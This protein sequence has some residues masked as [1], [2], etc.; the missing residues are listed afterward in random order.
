MKKADRKLLRQSNQKSELQKILQLTA[1]IVAHGVAAS[2]N[3]EVT[4]APAGPAEGAVGGTAASVGQTNTPAQLPEVV[5]TGQHH[6]SYKPVTPQL[7]KLTEPLRDTP[8]SITV[9]PRQVLDDQNATTLRDALRNVAGISIAA[10]EGGSQGDNLTLRG[11]TARG[12]IF[13]D[14]MRDFGSYYRDPFNMGEV[15]VL[16]GPESVM[17]GRGS[18]GGVINQQ[19]KTPELHPFT[20]ATLSLGS[21]LTRRATADFN[22]PI[23]ALGTGTAFRLNMMGH[24]SEVAERDVAQNRRFG[25]A[26]TLEFGI[27]TPTRLT[28]SYFH[29]SEDNIPD[30]GI[31]WLFDHPAPVSRDNFYGFETDYLKTD[32]DIVTARLESEVNQNITLRD[33]ARFGYYQRDFRITEPRIATGVTPTTPHSAIGITRNELAGKSVES[34]LDNQLDLTARF[35][36][37][38]IEHTVVTGVEISR[39]TSDPTRYA[40]TGVP[41]TSLVNPN[42]N[43]RFAGTSTV[44]SDVRTTALGAGLYALESMKLNEHLELSGGI[45][46]DYFDADYSNLNTQKFS[47]I[48]RMPSWRAAAVYKPVQKGSIYFDYGTSFNPSAESLSLSAANVD[49]APEKNQTFELGT[50]W[51][52]LDERLSLRAAIFRTD[53]TNVREP[54]PNDPTQ[55]VL[56]GVQRVDG[57]EVEAAGRLTKNWQV[58]SGYSYM[59]GEVMES[60]FYPGSVGKPLAN[61]PKNTFSLWTTYELPWK[62]ELGS[63]FH[64]V[65]ARTASSTVPI[66]PT[67]LKRKEAPGYW[68]LDALV[69]YHF[70]T[71]LEFQLNVYNI[72][73]NK[74][75][76]QLHPGHIVP[77]AGTTGVLSANLKF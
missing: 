61:V 64:Y 68:T 70:N 44:S 48:D 72:T 2:A 57:V 5:I 74:Y 75:Y 16:K 42:E 38:F 33:Q 21:D 73:N 60:K 29:Q 55:N 43:Q 7:P 51:D 37:G 69:K 27:G 58:F 35:N 63:G 41:T 12:D 11:F 34:I 18:T 4:N 20:E 62:L 19:S 10:G 24:E 36:T 9:V 28:F 6:E 17:F 22:Q 15:D 66:D 13:L 59:H 14:G 71:H 40:Y 52:L 47:R 32:V 25:F 31:P 77:G 8:Q 67:T 54:D 1:L 50:K 39:E 23:P 26:P 76:D 56:G 45:R 65:G 49:T 3:A 30:Y 46:W 53:K